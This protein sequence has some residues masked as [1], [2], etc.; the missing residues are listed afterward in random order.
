MHTWN[1]N[2]KYFVL[3]KLRK[4]KEKRESLLKKKGWLDMQKNITV[5]ILQIVCHATDARKKISFIV[6][7]FTS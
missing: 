7:D 1:C 2:G 6:R 4:A 5:I 3:Y